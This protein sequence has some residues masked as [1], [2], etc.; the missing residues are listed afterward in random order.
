MMSEFARTRAMPQFYR[1]I[2]TRLIDL[3]DVDAMPA[4]IVAE[5]FSFKS[6]DLEHLKPMIAAAK[7]GLD[8]GKEAALKHM[9]LAMTLANRVYESDEQGKPKELSE[10]LCAQMT[11]HVVAALKADN[12][13]DYIVAAIQVLFRVNEISSALFLINNHLSRVSDSGPVLKILLLVCLMEEDYNQAMVVIQ[14]LASD[15]ALIGEDPLTLLMIACAIY[16]LGGLPDSFI[17]FRS[18]DGNSS[19]RD[20]GEEYTWFIEKESKENTTVLIACDKR[21]YFIHALSLVYS[22]YET[23][24][25]VLDI[26]LHLY[27][28]DDEVKDSVIALRQQ[29]PELHISAT[30]EQVPECKNMPLQYSVRRTIFLE[31]AL[32]QFATPMISINADL[33]VR[34]SW[35]SPGTPL[36]LLQNEASPFWE[37][38]FAGFLYAEPESL[39]QRY[40]DI[41]KRFIESNLKDETYPLCM[42]QVALIASLDRLSGTEQMVISRVAQNTVLD[43]SNQDDVFCWLFSDKGKAGEASQQYKASLI[44]KYQR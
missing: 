42:E 36:L 6:A 35:V 2:F 18:L 38:I 1:D 39:T 37:T 12:N 10:E 31:Y 4:R 25:G 9:L 15:A 29:L 26:H 24:R 5:I 19:S 32:R 20:D 11:E 16:K 17:D 30:L 14:V 13:T 3:P 34:K 7:T 43:V 33:L 41:V 40:F 22:L 21:D 28:A 8:S 23:N 27:N 44:K